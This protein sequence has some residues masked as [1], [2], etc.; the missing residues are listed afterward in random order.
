MASPSREKSLALVSRIVTAIDDK[1][2]TDIRVIDVSAQSGVTDFFIIA[3]G[4]ADQHLRGLRIEIERVLDEDGVKIIGV[5]SQPESGWTVVDCFDVIVHLFK[6]EQRN[7]FQFEKLWK[8]GK[9]LPAKQFITNLERKVH[10]QAV[11]IT[12]NSKTPAPK[13][14]EPVAKKP[15]PAAKKPVAAKKPAKAA[16][17]PAKKAPAAKEPVVK[18]GV[19]AIVTGEARIVRRAAAKAKATRI[20][21]ENAAKTKTGKKPKPVKAAVKKIIAK[22]EAKAAK[23]VRGALK[24]KVKA[25]KVIKK[26]APAAKAGVVTRK[27]RKI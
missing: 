10:E 14:A 3:T 27:A 4:A 9:E 25:A 21:E 18:A 1:K 24:E 8:D 15:A 5:E 17:K 26:P 19:K 20:A 16:A 7:N 6:A 13:K 11:P 12:G 23:T 22:K 2:A